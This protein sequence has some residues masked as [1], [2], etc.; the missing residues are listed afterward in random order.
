MPRPKLAADK[1]HRVISVSLSPRALEHLEVF[2]AQYRAAHQQRLSRSQAV[3]TLILQGNLPSSSDEAG[4][5][6]G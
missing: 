6:R 2:Q 1:Q 3:E 4:M 5:P